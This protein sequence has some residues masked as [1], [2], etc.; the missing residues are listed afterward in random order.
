MSTEDN[1]GNS[2]AQSTETQESGGEDRFKNLQSEVNRKLADLNNQ[3]AQSNQDMKASLETLMSTLQSRQAAGRSTEGTEKK[4][5]ELLYEDPEQAV[6]QITRNVTREVSAQNATQQQFYNTAAQIEAEY[7]E[8]SNRA[9]PEYSRVEAYYKALPQHLVGTKEGIEISAYKA[10]AELGLQPRS[11]RQ[12]SGS[13]DF[14]VSSGG[15]SNQ[16]NRRPPKDAEVSDLQNA[17]AGMLL[18]DT[19][20]NPEFQKILKTATKR[21]TWNR[22][23]AF[24]EED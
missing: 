24:G 21:K 23:K 22:N 12:K 17:F 6:A 2:D 10:A 9:S 18:G 15:A 8:F 1:K 19:A 4:I 14:A 13:D 16:A 5:S 3:F 11:K 20:K 7:P